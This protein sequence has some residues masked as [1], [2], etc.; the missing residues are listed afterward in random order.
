MPEHAV[1][2]VDDDPVFLEAL[3]L[4][5]ESTFEVRTAANGTEALAAVEKSIPDV[6]VLDVMMDH[7]SEGFDVARKLKSDPRTSHVPVVMLTGVDQVYDYR[8]EIDD[9]FSPHDVFLEKPVAPE[10]LLEVLKEVCE[11]SRKASPDE[12]ET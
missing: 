12:K 9:S 11:R 1:L 5:L 8:M 3:I 6:V 4:V 7:L 2:L 10:K